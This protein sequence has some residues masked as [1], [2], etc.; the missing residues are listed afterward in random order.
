MGCAAARRCVLNYKLS[1]PRKCICTVTPAT[2]VLLVFHGNFIITAL[3]I[4][5]HSINRAPSLPAL[6]AAAPPVPAQINLAPG[7]GDKTHRR[8]PLVCSRRDRSR[9][10]SHCDSSPA[11]TTLQTNRERARREKVAKSASFSPPNDQLSAHA[12][13]LPVN[14]RC[15]FLRS[16][17]S[18]CVSN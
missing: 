8:V 9:S 17:I 13:Q 1:Q 7:E 18:V 2:G 4:R 16:A 6:P 14:S 15:C 11:T 3:G 5:S 12:T 10:I